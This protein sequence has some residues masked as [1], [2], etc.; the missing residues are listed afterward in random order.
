M[1]SGTPIKPNNRKDP[2]GTFFTPDP[3]M[4]ETMRKNVSKP[5]GTPGKNASVDKINNS[6]VKKLGFEG[7]RR[8]KRKTRKTKRTKTRRA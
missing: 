8:S 2:E 1:S 7:G 5:L 3:K 4:P 6:L